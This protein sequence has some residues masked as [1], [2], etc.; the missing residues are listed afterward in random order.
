MC[1]GGGAV[2]LA[3]P[4][5]LADRIGIPNPVPSLGVPGLILPRSIAGPL[6]LGSS[7]SI[8]SPGRT[9]NTTTLS[10]PNPFAANMAEAQAA[11]PSILQML[12]RGTLDTTILGQNRRMPSAAVVGSNSTLGG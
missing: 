5:R 9:T 1:I 8:S 7:P 2:K 11:G 12:G 6:G 4:L 10:P 3:N